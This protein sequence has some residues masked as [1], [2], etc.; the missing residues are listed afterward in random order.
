M[1]RE[2]NLPRIKLKVAAAE[3]GFKKTEKIRQSLGLQSAV[4][5]LQ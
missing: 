5:S 3:K 1:K 2:K 4:T